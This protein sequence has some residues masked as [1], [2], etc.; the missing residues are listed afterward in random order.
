MKKS[1]K[2]ILSALL[3]LVLCAVSC[4]FGAANSE[5]IKAVMLYDR[6]IKLDGVVQTMKDEDGNRVYPVSY[7]GTTYLPIRAISEMLGLGVDWDGANNT[8]ILTTKSTSSSSNATPSGTLIMDAFGVQ[9]YYLGIA[10]SPYLE[11]KDVKFKIV[12]NTNKSIYVQNRE[13]SVNGVMVDA[14]LTPL[15]APGKTAVDRMYIRESSLDEGGITNIENIE[16]KLCVFD[17]DKW[18]DFNES[19]FITIIP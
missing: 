10:D 7:H 19:D 4:A 5:E 13:V 11:G 6:A 15:V 3:I 17:S 2:R 12:N 14:N 18:S 9:V 1:I 16:F 8:V